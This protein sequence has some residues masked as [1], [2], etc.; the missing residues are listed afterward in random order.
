MKGWPRGRG[1][2]QTENEGCSPL[3]IPFCQW[4]VHHAD[5]MHPHQDAGSPPYAVTNSLPLPTLS[6]NDRKIARGGVYAALS[7]RRSDSHAPRVTVLK[8]TALEIRSWI[9]T[10]CKQ[11]YSMITYL[12]M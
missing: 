11:S 3:P 9:F 7:G 5:A 4:S 8:S 2:T 1:R 10:R 12:L 6:S